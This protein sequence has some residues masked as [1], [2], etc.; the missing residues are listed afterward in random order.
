MNKE[1]KNFVEEIINISSLTNSTSESV[2]GYPVQ[3]DDYEYNNHFITIGEVDG[4]HYVEIDYAPFYTDTVYGGNFL[5][6]IE[7]DP[8]NANVNNEFNNLIIN[9]VL[10][11]LNSPEDFDEVVYFKKYKNELENTK[12]VW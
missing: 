7:I 10:D 3:E 2:L 11:I 12:F 1:Y 5:D 8:Y 4:N 6:K 9:I